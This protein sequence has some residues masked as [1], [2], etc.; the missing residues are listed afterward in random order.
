[1]IAFT[2]SLAKELAQTR[3]RVNSVAPAAVDTPLLE[4]GTPEFLQ[5]MIDKSPLMR[6]GTIHKVAQLIMWLSSDAC[7]FNTGAC[8]GL[9]GGR[10]IY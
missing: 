6:L 9:S 3:S 4:Q 5:I 1:M 2:K 8:V 10:A 7:S